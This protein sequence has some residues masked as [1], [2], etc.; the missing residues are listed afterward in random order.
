MG[1]EIWAATKAA[2]IL[3]KNAERNQVTQ[4]KKCYVGKELIRHGSS[5]FSFVPPHNQQL[6]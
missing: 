4:R 3:K 6:A 5:F 2:H 1:G